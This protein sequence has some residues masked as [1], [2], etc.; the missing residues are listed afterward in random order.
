[1]FQLNDEVRCCGVLS[2]GCDVA[3]TL[4]KSPQLGCQGFPQARAANIQA[5]VQ[6]GLSGVKN[7]KNK[8]E[9]LSRD[10]G[11]IGSA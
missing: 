9:I 3:T 1:M 8:G 10:G 6:I 5:G 11:C 4:R 7:T 2:A